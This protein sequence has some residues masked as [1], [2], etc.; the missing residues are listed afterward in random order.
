MHERKALMH[1]LS[2]GFAVLPGGFG[3]LDE[4]MELATWNQLGFHSKAVI[5]INSHRFFDP[6]VDPLDHMVSEGLV[7]PEDRSLVQVAEDAREALDRLGHPAPAPH[8]EA[9]SSPTS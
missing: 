8:R 3:T 6:L 9:H 4:A 2:D 1:R 7:S 5:L